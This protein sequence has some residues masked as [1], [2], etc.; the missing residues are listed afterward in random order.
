VIIE[1]AAQDAARDAVRV[2]D[3]TLRKAWNIMDAAHE[4]PAPSQYLKPEAI[5]AVQGQ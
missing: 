1:S 3:A 4:K 5:R 2:A